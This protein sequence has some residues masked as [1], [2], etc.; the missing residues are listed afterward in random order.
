MLI[1]LIP[2]ILL[3]L[4]ILL[5]RELQLAFG[6][7]VRFAPFWPGVLSCGRSVFGCVGKWDVVFERRRERTVTTTD[8]QAWGKRG[9]NDA[10]PD[11]LVC[12][13]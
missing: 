13:V 11:Y 1:L 5:L 12:S 9:R 8:R 7:V 2:L 10:L 6:L 4:L 3:I